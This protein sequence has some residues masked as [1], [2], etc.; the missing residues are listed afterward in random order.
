LRVSVYGLLPD[1]PLRYG[2]YESVYGFDRGEPVELGF[3]AG[4][5]AELDG[6][7]G[8]GGGGADGR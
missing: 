4:L 1:E 8:G 2:L 6:L 5:L 3:D 7:E